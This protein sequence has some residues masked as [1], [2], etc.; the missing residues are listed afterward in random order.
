MEKQQT[1]VDLFMDGLLEKKLVKSSIQNGYILGNLFQEC[2]KKERE[3][4]QNAQLDIMK[5]NWKLPYFPEK[6]H[7]DKTEKYYNETFK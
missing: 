6:I 5:D 4:L 7:L 3:Q 1:A 2:L